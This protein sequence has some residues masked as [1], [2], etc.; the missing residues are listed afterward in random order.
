MKI[1]KLTADTKEAVI[2]ALQ[3]RSPEGYVTE[4]QTVSKIIADVR[5]RGDEALF[6]YTKEYDGF[7]LAASNIRVGRDEIDEAYRLV[8]EDLVGVYRR[9]ARNIRQFH[10]MQKRTSFFTTDENGSM[11]G[12]RF[13]PI[14]RAGVYAPGGKA[15]YPSSVLMNAIPAKVAGVSEIIL[16]TPCNKEGKV[17][18]N[19]LVAADIAGVD[20]VLRIGGAQAIAALAFGTESV[21]RV[22]KITGPGNIYV[23]LA[24]KAVF[25][26][27]GID[28]VAGPSE[29]T[30]L[31]DDSAD[32]RFVAA[33]LISQAEHDEMASSILVTTSETLAT[34]VIDE[35]ERQV[36][37]L[38]RKEIIQKSLDHY[39]QVLIAGTLTD[40]CEAVDA[41][42]PEHLEILTREPMSV[43]GRIHN[44]G[45]IFLG[46]YSSEP[47]G[48]YYAGPNHILPTSGTARFF[49]PL[50]VDDFM[51]RNSVI[52]YSKEALA[53]AH[54]DI[55]AFAHSEGLDAHAASIA[56][57][58][59]E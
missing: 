26:Q 4:E 54:E 37:V 27:V 46:Q 29:I 28:S 11:L 45:A 41:I 53:A 2:T 22:D 52:Y 13:L 14:R 7:A 9:A 32:P 8:G 44:A 31:A 30:V 25:G 47:L 3:S 38:P 19:T 10:E 39:G 40:A 6:A 35:I 49:S 36:R 20:A 48:D 21:P 15:A 51:K 58:F 43:M 24:K 34:A 42:A 12:Q 1:Q 56:S 55:E 18:P 17:Y 23:A 33:D 5:A 16:A 57:R 50:G 59:R